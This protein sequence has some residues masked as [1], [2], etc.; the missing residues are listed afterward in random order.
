MRYLLLGAGLQ[1]T[2]IAFDLL[3][4]APDTA[5]LTV[6]DISEQA[7]GRL[8][9]R[10]NDPRLRC[11][12]GDVTDLAFLA[13]LIEASDCVISAVTYWHNDK[14][15]RAAIEG[16]SHFIDLGGN[17][18][19]VAREMS[20]DAMARERGVTVLPDCG[21]SPGL[22]GILGYHLATQFEACDALRLRAGGLPRNPRPPLNYQLE[23][24]V[25]GLLN[26]YIEPA[27]VIRD[28][29]ARTVPPLSELES[30]H[31]PE[32]YGE[33]EAFQTSGGTSTLPRTL[34]NRVRQLDYK[35]IRYRGHCDHL[36]LLYSL[37]MFS[38]AEVEVGG[39][40]IKPREILETMLERTLPTEGDD[41]VLVLIEADGT[42]PASDGQPARNVRRS[43]RIIDGNDRRHAMSAMMRMTGYPASII[44]QMLARGDVHA[45]GAHC[46]ELIVPAEKVL[47]ELS[48]RGVQI[49][50]WDVELSAVQG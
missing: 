10:L 21:L 5:D 25:H 49:E 2:A 15:A 11:V 33:L 26:E 48:R 13:P 29:R 42:L 32:P 24:S 30:V 17:N 47:A 36:R 1:G 40:Q 45:P 18:D 19:V 23:F 37:G 43:M 34:E 6:V 44:A 7:I 28:G 41:V 31:F 20:L 16:G 14:L 39:Q 35:T 9:S 46:Q 27:L 12:R 4:H 3:E 8:G 38:A 22:T 50:T